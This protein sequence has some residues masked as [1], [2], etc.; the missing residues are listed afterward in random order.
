M[1][2]V[3][4]FGKVETKTQSFPVGTAET[5]W[6]FELFD[7]NGFRVSFIEQS[8]PSTIFPDVNQGQ[9][10]TMK[11]T[12]NGVTVSQEFTTPLVSSD[13]EVP[14]SLTITFDAV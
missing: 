3:T 10:Y 12:K 1:S 5:L 11:V 7:K 4:V 13:L 2:N 6:L 8:V 9:K 14:V